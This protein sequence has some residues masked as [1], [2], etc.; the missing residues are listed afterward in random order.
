M[1]RTQD[2][3]PGVVS[4]THILWTCN[5]WQRALKKY[6]KGVEFVEHD[7][8]FSDQE[9]KESGEIKKLCNLNIAA[10]L[11]KLGDSKEARKT[12]SKVKL[13]CWARTLSVA[14]P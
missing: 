2:Q 11:L 3:R 12:C 14:L 7:D 9:K 4:V 8:Q 5:R 13:S 1:T 6:K 10:V